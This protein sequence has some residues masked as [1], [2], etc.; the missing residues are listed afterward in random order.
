LSKAREKARAISCMSNIK[1]IETGHL[2]YTNDYDDYL[3]P[4]AGMVPGDNDWVVY[5][6]GITRYPIPY[7]FTL[8]PLI[9]G[10]PMSAKEWYDKDNAAYID[11]GAADNSSWH[12]I[13]LCPS[14]PT[15]TR[16]TGNI[17]YQASPG[18]G[19]CGKIIEIGWGYATTD[20]RSKASTWHRVSSIK[21]PSLHVNIFDGSRNAGWSD[22]IVL[23]P[24]NFNSTVCKTEL[25]RHALCLNANFS[26]GH[27]EP[28]A[29][30]KASTTHP[31]LGGLNI[32]ADFYWYPNCDVVGGDK[33]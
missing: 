2:I 22:A 16:V 26:D 8:N 17:C 14:A 15:N 4:I 31:T 18:L 9:P 24:E 5:G 25:F 28:V 29:F 13:M 19:N 32:I 12:K 1:Q 3:P 23:G 21:Y 20:A 30:S 10:A 11:G 27:A 33:R 6:N 7:W